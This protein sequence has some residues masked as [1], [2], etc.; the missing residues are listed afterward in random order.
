MKPTNLTDQQVIRGIINEDTRIY[1]YLYQ[2]YGPIVLAHVMKNSGS[3]EDGKEILQMTVLRVWDKISA[4]QYQ[5]QGKLGQYFYMISAN[6]WKEELRRRRRKPTQTLGKTE[7]YVADEGDTD[8][9]RKMVKS[10]SMDA[11]YRAIDRLGELC[12]EII[13]LYHLQ[14]VPLKEIAVQKNYDYN[15]L[16]KRIF[17]CRKK[18]R[19]LAEEELK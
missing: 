14:E 16:R 12:Q 15:N 9:F 7:E 19:K 13:E 18:L 2:K 6:T 3:K 4:G 8:L 17:N 11:I 1:K 5:D 10:K